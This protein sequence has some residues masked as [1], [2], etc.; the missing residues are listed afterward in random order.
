MSM[1][2]TLL[3]NY[4]H[5]SYGTIV[6]TAIIYYVEGQG[7]F[8]W[9]G[10]MLEGPVNRVGSWMMSGNVAF[11]IFLKWWDCFPWLGHQIML[12]F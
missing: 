7:S 3:D 11:E 10:G 6:F 8:F 12:S 5:L 2:S 4:P 9:W 1:L